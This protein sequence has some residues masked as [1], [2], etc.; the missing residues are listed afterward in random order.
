[1]AKLKTNPDILKLL[2]QSQA[3][4]YISPKNQETLNELLKLLEKLKLFPSNPTGDI[5]TGEVITINYY[6]IINNQEKLNQNEKKIFK[7]N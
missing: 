7:N 2:H 6:P 5:R 1:M 3:Q 4:I